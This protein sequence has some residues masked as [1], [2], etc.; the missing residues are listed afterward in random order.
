LEG[1]HASTTLKLDNVRTFLL[2][3]Q[4]RFSKVRDTIVFMAG[5]T[6]GV[7]SAPM[8]LDSGECTG[9]PFVCHQ[10]YLRQEMMWPWMVLQLAKKFMGE[11]GHGMCFE[12]SRCRTA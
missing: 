3:R 9:L 12:P 1:W 5:T 7:K 6:S 2:I 11:G 4:Y 10:R 8:R